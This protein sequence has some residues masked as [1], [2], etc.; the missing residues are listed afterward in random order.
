[1]SEAEAAFLVAS[2]ILTACAIYALAVRL[3]FPMLAESATSGYALVPDDPREVVIAVVGTLT[4]MGTVAGLVS[5][6]QEVLGAIVCAAVPVLYLVRQYWLHTHAVCHGCRKRLGVYRKDHRSGS[7]IIL[8][9]VC[10]SCRAYQ[11][12]LAIGTGGD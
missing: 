11:E 12:R 2:G 7:A 8:V 5:R 10:R 4:W 3:R 1:M 9:Y 6:D